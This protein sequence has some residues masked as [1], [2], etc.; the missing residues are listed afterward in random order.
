MT[1]DSAPVSEEDRETLNDLLGALPQ[2]RRPLPG[3][4]ESMR[5]RWPG[6]IHD[7]FEEFV[8]ELRKGRRQ[9]E[10]QR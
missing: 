4:F 3:S 7:G 2:P 9:Q 5:G 10:P 6:D 1:E 8:R